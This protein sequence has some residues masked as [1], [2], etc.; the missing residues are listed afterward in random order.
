MQYDFRHQFNLTICQIGAGV[1]YG[2]AK[3]LIEQLAADP[4]THLCAELNGWI[5][6]IGVQDLILADLVDITIKVNS[7]KKKPD[8]YP[9][10]WV[11]AKK[12]ERLADGSKYSPES[13]LNILTRIKRGQI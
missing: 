8:P 3:H 13:G 9:R 6:P 1:T 7:G 4:S 2:E 5:F 11:K 12:S 10:P